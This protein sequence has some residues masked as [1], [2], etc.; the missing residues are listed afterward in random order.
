MPGRSTYNPRTLH[1]SRARRPGRSAAGVVHC[2]LKPDNVLLT[3]DGRVEILDFGLA[4]DLP[5]PS[6]GAG[7]TRQATSPGTVL[8][9]VAYMSPEQARGA[10]ADARSD[11]FALGLV[12]YELAS[13]RQAFTRDTAVQT[14][15]ARPSSR[16]SRTWRRWRPC[17]RRFVGSSSAAWPRTRRTGTRRPSISRGTCDRSATGSRSFPS[18]ASGISRRRDRAV[19]GWH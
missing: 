2:D 13:G 12:L 18:R 15:S 4:R 10:A 9:T 6:D 19:A 5:G 11:Q 8:G 16:P 17:P 1:A 14:L 3:R 7:V